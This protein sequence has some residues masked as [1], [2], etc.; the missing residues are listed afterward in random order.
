MLSSEVSCEV[1]GQ[2]HAGVVIK[3]EV[4]AVCRQL[5]PQQ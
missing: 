5:E 2:V 3:Q 1:N 4:I